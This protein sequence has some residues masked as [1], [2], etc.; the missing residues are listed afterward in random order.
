MKKILM[1]AF[2]ALI[3][4]SSIW[5]AKNWSDI[6]ADYWLLRTDWVISRTKSWR[7][8]L[9]STNPKYPKE[10]MTIEAVPPDRE[11]GWQHID[12]AVEAGG[13]KSTRIAGDIEHIRVRDDRYFRPASLVK[14]EFGERIMVSG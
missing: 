7:M 14:R 1:F 2:A 3:A 4:A 12:R 13:S 10:W 11:H 8:R 6:R 9:Q 5:T